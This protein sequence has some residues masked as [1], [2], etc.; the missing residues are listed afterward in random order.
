MDDY[1][2]EQM[3]ARLPR[4][5][6]AGET[7]LHRAAPDLLAACEAALAVLMRDWPD[8]MD[9]GLSSPRT[10]GRARD[11]KAQLRAAIERAT[12]GAS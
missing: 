7:A 3:T 8:D 2:A 1:T 9:G 4:I 6:H 5:V 11:A 10:P 12:G